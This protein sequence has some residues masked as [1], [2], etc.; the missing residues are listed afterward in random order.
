VG[1]AVA[2]ALAEGLLFGV[3]VDVERVAAGAGVAVALL[4]GVT[5]ELLELTLFSELL[6]AAT[7]GV[8]STGGTTAGLVVTA[9]A[10]VETISGGA[11]G[12]AEGAG[13]GAVDTVG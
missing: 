3:A 10:G 12:S 9:G 11:T 8:A 13:S 1:F 4:I 7:A 2:V 6:L 5:A